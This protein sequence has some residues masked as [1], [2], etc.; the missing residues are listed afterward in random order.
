M[1]LWSYRGVRIPPKQVKAACSSAKMLAEDG[2]SKLDLDP[3]LVHLP[4]VPSRVQGSGSR[5]QELWL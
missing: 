1:N 4:D 5:A 3:E 2:G